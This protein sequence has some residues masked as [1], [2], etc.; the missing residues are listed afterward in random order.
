[1]AKQEE[2]TTTRRTT[3]TPDPDPQSITPHMPSPGED[4]A[5]EAAED[6]KKD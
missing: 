6:D 1:M 2:E 5:R 4:Q 3:E